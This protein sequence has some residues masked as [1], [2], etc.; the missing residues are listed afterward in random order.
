MNSADLGAEYQ[1]LWTDQA[2]E[3]ARLAR[4]K[5]QLN[6]ENQLGSGATASTPVATQL[7][8]D[9]VTNETEQLALW[10]ADYDKEMTFLTRAIQSATNQLSELTE[11]QAKEKEGT[12]ADAAELQRLATF[13]QQ[14]DVTS[15]RV[16]DARRAMLLSSTRVLQTE[17]QII[18]ITREKE[19]YVHQIDKLKDDARS[20]TL[21]ELEES[22][23]RFAALNARI[24][25]TADKMVYTS[26]MRSQLPIS[27]L[28]GPSVTIMRGYRD[29]WSRLD[30]A[31][32]TVLEPGDVIEISVV[33]KTKVTEK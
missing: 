13:N 11:Q 32:D 3:Q 5:A 28:G 21:K 16:V 8:T 7:Q 24:A 22:Q 23:L 33:P 12:A 27:K 2:R 6:N 14:G 18:Q 15:N 4:L 1:T 19:G 29:N 30:A 10:H 26:T 25:A 20:A 17:E 9:L 31:E